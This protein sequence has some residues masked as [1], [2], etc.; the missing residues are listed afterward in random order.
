MTNICAS[1]VL[2]NSNR[3]QLK[4]AINSFLNTELDVTLFLID[5][6]FNNKL[7]SLTKL[8]SRIKYIF[9]N[10]NLGF[11]RAHNIAIKNSITNDSKYHL[12]L[13]PDVYFET[14]VLENIFYF[15]EDN[16]DV[17]SLMPKVLYPSGSLQYLCK[18]LP[19][20]FN[21]FLRGLVP[22]GKFKNYISQNYELRSFDYDSIANIPS[23]SGCFMF[24]RNNIYETVGMFDENFFLH[25]EDVD[26]N[27]RI[28]QKYKTIFYPN[29]SIY[30]EN[31]GVKTNFKVLLLSIKSGFYYFSKWGWFFDK[32]RKRVNKEA[33]LQL[34]KTRS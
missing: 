4:K 23:L 5:N 16:S 14:G 10:G 15:M 21:F 19:T 1:I 27:R 24:T 9:N 34:K 3:E 17:G 25:V 22:S 11:G 26:L 2:Y 32:E 33:I 31:Q 12:I 7:E 8:D 6:S 29:V 13:N 18:L 20:P 30:H 28:H